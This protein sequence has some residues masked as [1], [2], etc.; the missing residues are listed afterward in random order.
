MPIDAATGTAIRLASLVFKNRSVTI[1]RSSWL[2]IGRPSSSIAVS[3]SAALFKK[4]PISQLSEVTIEES[5][6][7][8]RLCSSA[9]L[10]NLRGFRLA[11][12]SIADIPRLKN[13]VGKI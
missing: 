3:F 12:N 2:S 9:E 4:K 10:E 11:F 7:M 5:W 8:A 13:S 1:R 6:T